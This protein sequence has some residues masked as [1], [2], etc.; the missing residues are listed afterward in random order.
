MTSG[1]SSMA[2]RMLSSCSGVAPAC[3]NTMNSMPPSQR[4]V[5]LP[6]ALREDQRRP[7][8]GEGHATVSTEATVRLRLRRR[9]VAVSRE[10]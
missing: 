6:I 10:T 3:M 8:Q 4:A 1:L 9:L 2:V 5:M 7:E